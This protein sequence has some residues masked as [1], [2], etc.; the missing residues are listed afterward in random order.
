VVATGAGPALRLPYLYVVGTATPNLPGSG[1]PADTFAI[2]NA[3]FVGPVKNEDWRMVLRV[4]DTYGVP[5]IGN[6]VRFSIVKGEGAFGFGDDSSHLL[7]NSAVSLNLGIGE[8]VVQGFV[9]GLS[10]PVTFDG[11][12]RNLPKIRDTDGVL[13]AAS[14]RLDQG[15]APGSYIS[16]YGTDLADV[17][18][19]EPTPYLPVSLSAVTV[20]FDADGVSQPGHLHFVSPG[21]VNVQI[22]WELQGKSSAKMKVGIQGSVPLFGAPVPVTLAAYSPAMFESGGLAIAQDAQ[23]ALITRAHAASRSGAVVLYVNGLGAVSNTPPSGE[24]SGS[25]TSLSQT[26]STPTVTVGGKQAQVLFSG[27]TPGVVGLYQINAT[28]AADTPTGDQPI[29]VSIG[30]VSSKTAVLPVQ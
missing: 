30:G 25:G 1:A 6:P 26:T 4:I 18:Q 23:G 11:F 13:N 29:V 12:A 7:G 19:V 17:L 10:T 14:N 27:L 28:L 5:L 15:L 8:Q 3:S 20:T 24:A 22:P 2:H 9:Q 16:I 21:Q